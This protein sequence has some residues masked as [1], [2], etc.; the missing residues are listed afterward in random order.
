MGGVKD[1]GSVPLEAVDGEGDLRAG[2]YD[3]LVEAEAV[4][5]DQGG[6]VLV[7]GFPGADLGGGDQGLSIGGEGD[8]PGGQALQVGAG[9]EGG[10]VGHIEGHG[11]P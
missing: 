7:Q 9:G 5:A 6:L 1:G 4:D 11:V 2:C 3:L 10:G 8:S